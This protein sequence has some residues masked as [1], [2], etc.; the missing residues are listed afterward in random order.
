MS[1]LTAVVIHGEGPIHFEYCFSCQGQ[2]KE[3]CCLENGA[4]GAFLFGFLKTP[5]L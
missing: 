4:E 3:S 1:D 2:G 5:H